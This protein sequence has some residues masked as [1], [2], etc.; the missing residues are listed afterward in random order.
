[1][2]SWNEVRQ[3]RLVSGLEDLF[4][5]AKQ[6][7]PVMRQA[8]PEKK[9]PVSTLALYSDPNNWNKGRVICLIHSE[10]QTVLGHFQEYRHKRE[11][12]ARRL[13]RM[14]E[15]AAIHHTEYVSGSWWLGDARKDEIV[16]PQRWTAERDLLLED[17]LLP[18]LGVHAE[19]V[20]V[21]CYLSYGGIARVELIHH[22]TFH[23][24]DAKV[25]LTLAAATNILECLDLA[26]KVAI[27]KELM[28]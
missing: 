12:G 15:P 16:S 8:T 21:R 26:G 6:Y 7:L 17:V 23:S 2:S 28:V 13:E 20:D 5:D 24:P 22:T 18:L 19:L 1:M 10:S 9:K 4:D 25:V 11:I 14:E 27:R 3:P